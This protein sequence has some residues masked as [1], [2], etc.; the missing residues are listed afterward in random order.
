MR[1]HVRHSANIGLITVDQAAA[2]L[3]K[4]KERIRQLAAQGYIPKAG[5]DQYPLVGVVQGYIRFR[6]DAAQRGEP[7]RAKADLDRTRAKLI[8]LRTK[9][10]AARLVPTA[11]VEAYVQLIVAEF[12]SRMEMLPS[13][14]CETPVERE[15]L[16]TIVARIRVE[17]AELMERHSLSR[18]G[19]DGAWN[20]PE[21][22]R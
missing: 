13:D 16:S 17:M 10:A 9:Q 7:G 1:P 5:R 21:D 3:M 14:L 19:R 4:S 12:L 20:I 15:R 22:L 2:L 18:Q 11:E 6:D 8:E